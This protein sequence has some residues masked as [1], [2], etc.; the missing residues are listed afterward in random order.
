MMAFVM[1]ALSRQRAVGNARD[2]ENKL[3]LG[4]TLVQ[5]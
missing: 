2:C 3:I 4:V 5:T 1:M